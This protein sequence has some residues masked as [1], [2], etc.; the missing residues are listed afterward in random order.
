MAKIYTNNPPFVGTREDITIYR[1][2][3]D[4]VY[5]MRMKSSLTGKRVKKDPAFRGLMRHAGIMAIA[6]P[7]ASAVYQ[8]LP[9]AERKV[10]LYRKMTGIA[11]RMLKEGYSEE[12]VKE[13]LIAES[14]VSLPGKK[15]TVSTYANQIPKV[16]L[17]SFFVVNHSVGAFRFH[18]R[19]FNDGRQ[20][21]T[22]YKADH[23]RQGFRGTCDAIIPISLS[24]LY[25]RE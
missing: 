13:V 6:A 16:Q 8:L 18:R 2:K 12:V 19:P 1:M 20:N 9:E 23:R 7:L 15:E 5:Y 10:A 11:Q 3:A 22:Q 17:D 14:G 24:I 21:R 25:S 4:G